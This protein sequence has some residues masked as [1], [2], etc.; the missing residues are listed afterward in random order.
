ML[1]FVPG[2]TTNHP[3]QRDEH[4][5]AVGGSLLR[6]LH[7]ATAGHELA[8]GGECV[9][10]GDPGPYNAVFADGLPTV[11]IDWDSARPGQ[12]MWDLGYLA[13]TWCIQSEGRVPIKDQ[14]RRVRAVRD[15][16]GVQDAESLLLQID[17]CQ[18][19]IAVT[20]R[21]QLSRPGQPEPV[22]AHHRRAIAWA[23]NDRTLLH[24]HWA[25]FLADLT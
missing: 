5:Y 6:R 19:Y 11:L 17:D 9:I 10:H 3:S 25:T 23:E 22:Y 16:Y 21:A 13:W 7:D 18:T 15:S 20:S 8:A 4:A 1:E 24:E 14:S 2:R 12:R